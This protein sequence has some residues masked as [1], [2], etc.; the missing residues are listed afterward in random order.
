VVAEPVG[1]VHLR[2]GVARAPIE[3]V[4]RGIVRTGDPGRRAAALPRVAL[5][6]VVARF[7]VAGDRVEAPR[8][9]SRLGVVGVDETANAVL[10][11]GH[12]D[13]DLVL[14]DERRA[15]DF[16]ARVGVR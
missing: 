8:P 1:A 12:A 3:Q 10:A 6:G 5:P 15:G 11:A 9:F 4:E 16:L 7:A 13:D 2:P 14:H